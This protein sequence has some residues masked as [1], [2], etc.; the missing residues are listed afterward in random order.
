[1]YLVNQFQINADRV[2][3]IGF[4]SSKPI[5][6]EVTDEH[7]QLNRRVEFEILKNN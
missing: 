3:A 6:Q 7:K 2:T 1:M 5:V 4:G